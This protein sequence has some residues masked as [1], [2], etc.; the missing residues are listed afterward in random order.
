MKQERVLTLENFR[1]SHA[2]IL[3]TFQAN[4]RNHARDLEKSVGQ[5]LKR[6]NTIIDKLR[7]EPNMP[8]SSMHDIAGCRIV[9]KSIE[10]LHSVRK[11][12]REARWRHSITHEIDKYDY[13]KSPKITGYR[14]I[15]DIYN[16]QVISAGGQP[17]NGLKIE[18]QF[19]TLPQHAWATAVEVADLITSNR[20]K[21]NDASQH[22][23]E[24]F[25]LA[26]EI[27]ARSAEGVKSCLY[28][29]EDV[30]L[31]RS[32]RALDKRLGLL[33][34]FE[35]LRGTAQ[36]NIKFKKNTLLI[37][38]FANSPEEA[39]LEIRS[40]DNVNRAIEAYDE[41]EKELGL[42]A[43]IVLVR[44]ETEENIRSAFRNYFSDATAFVDLIN[45]GLD[46]LS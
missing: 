20:I 37:F 14:G 28:Q 9:F 34:T 30:V 24:Y 44:G 43:D 8:L 40:F 13:I 29:M 36:K 26:S 15:H 7:R 12:M 2:Y 6:R 38:R 42:A 25:Q 19:R 33:T 46:Y 22:Y 32:F 41:L 45:N 23:L 11:S 35:N 16:Y 3:N 27:I 17:Y 31:V 18:V 39:V 21:F 10:D 5:R 4:I 1:A